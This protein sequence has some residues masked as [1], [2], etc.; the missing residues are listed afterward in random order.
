MKWNCFLDI[1]L[2]FEPGRSFFKP[3][4]YIFLRIIAFFFSGGDLAQK[5]NSKK[6]KNPIFPR[7]PKKHQFEEKVQA[8]REFLFF[9]WRLGRNKPPF[10]LKKSLLLFS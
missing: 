3:Y 9:P 1:F 8:Q 6:K 5:N 7:S 10:L 4:R 2:F